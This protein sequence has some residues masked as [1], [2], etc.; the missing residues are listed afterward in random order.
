M[1]AFRP[2]DNCSCAVRC[3]H[4]VR[5]HGRDGRSSRGLRSYRH[6][7]ILLSM[8]TGLDRGW[9][10]GKRVETGWWKQDGTELPTERH[11]ESRLV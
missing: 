9:A 11:P 7:E 1:T 10:E 8:V 2:G 3:Q 5:E 6:P 4:A